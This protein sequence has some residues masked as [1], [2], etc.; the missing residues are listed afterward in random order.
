VY[1]RAVAKIH[2]R[3]EGIFSAEEDEMILQ[4]VKKSRKLSAAIARL[5]VLLKRSARGI[6]KRYRRISRN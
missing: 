6:S 5:S 1:A 4:E 3:K 2:T